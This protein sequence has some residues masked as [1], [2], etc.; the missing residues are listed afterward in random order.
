MKLADN[1]SKQKETHANKLVDKESKRQEKNSEPK[2]INAPSSA[3]KPCSTKACAHIIRELRC[4]AVF[5]AQFFIFTK[6]DKT[7]ALLRCALIEDYFHCNKKSVSWECAFSWLTA[8]A[9]FVLS[10]M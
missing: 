3:K 6:V 7:K 8:M 5:Q 2:S 1:E 10:I 9:H 4:I